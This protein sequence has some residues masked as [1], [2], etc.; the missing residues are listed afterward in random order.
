[1]NGCLFETSGEQHAFVKSHD[2]HSVFTI[3]EGDTGAWYASPG[4][5]FVNRIGYLVATIPWEDDLK[6]FKL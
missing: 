3:V 5:H 2:Y 6:D 4:F 1:M